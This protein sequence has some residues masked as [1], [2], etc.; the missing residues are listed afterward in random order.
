METGKYSSYRPAGREHVPTYP[1]GFIAIRI[2]QLVVALVILGLCAY[3]LTLLSFSGNALSLFTAVATLI[4]TV[5]YVVVEFGPVN[6]YNYW[7]VLALDIF[8]IIFWTASFALLASQIAPYMGGY[9]VCDYY[10]CDTYALTG[11]ELTFGACLC[12][13]AGLGGVETILFMVALAY[14]SVMMHRHRSAGLHCKPMSHGHQDDDALHSSSI[15]LSGGP[16]AASEKTQPTQTYTA[17]VPQPR[18]ASSQQTAAAASTPT[19]PP[20]PPGQHQMYQPPT[21]AAA[22][23]ASPDMLA[24]QVPNYPEHQHQHQQHQY[25][26]NVQPQYS[27]AGFGGAGAGQLPAP[28]PGSYEAQGQAIGYQQHR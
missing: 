12:A 4:I 17:V 20:P 22:A 10:E 28:H 6:G 9:T 8:A 26:G 16:V 3:S 24:Q 14:H 7:A 23:A 18:Y 11:D 27:G 13:A 2:V 1:R 5:Y 21:A 25:Q 15:P 19:P